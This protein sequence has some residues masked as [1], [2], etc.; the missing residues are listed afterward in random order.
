MK[1]KPDIVV[2]VRAA[3]AC[4]VLVGCIAVM[5]IWPRAVHEFIWGLLR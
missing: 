2:D 3:I 1:R 5:A 4:Y